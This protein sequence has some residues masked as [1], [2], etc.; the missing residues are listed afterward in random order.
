[1]TAEPASSPTPESSAPKKPHFNFYEI[2]RALRTYYRMEF[3]I[4]VSFIG[5]VFLPIVGVPLCG[6]FVDSYNKPDY[7]LYLPVFLSALSLLL[8]IFCA[9]RRWLA[10]RRM[11]RLTGFRRE[12]DSGK[13][14]IPKQV[15]E[16]LIQA[17]YKT[18]GLTFSRLAAFREPPR[19]ESPSLES[20]DAMLAKP[21]EMPS[22][23]LLAIFPPRNWS[24]RSCFFALIVWLVVGAVGLS[25]F[26]EVTLWFFSN[27]GSHLVRKQIQTINTLRHLAEELNEYTADHGEYPVSLAELQNEDQEKSGDSAKLSE[28][29]LSEEERRALYESAALQPQGESYQD[30]WHK[31]IYY[32][33]DGKSWTLASYGADGEPGGVGIDADVFLYNATPD[34]DVNQFL[35]ES[36][37]P[38]SQIIKSPDY[39]SAFIFIPIFLILTLIGGMF[40]AVNKRKS[41]RLPEMLALLVLTFI[42]AAIHAFLTSI[43]SGH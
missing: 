25:L 28:P 15:A 2:A 1:M 11:T 30:S 33:S 38:L 20:S 24:P 5:L 37:P 32:Q 41:I 43:P 31:P 18:S 39:Q 21:S 35:Q 29:K 9:I 13:P 7:L 23:T 6:I 26:A 3:A 10:V 22:D 36:K 40:D 27:N 34:I 14:P 17:G 16:F 42:F 12:F 19:G 8:L 4:V